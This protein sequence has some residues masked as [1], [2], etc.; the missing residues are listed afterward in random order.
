MEFDW[1]NFIFSFGYISLD[2][3]HAQVSSY[4]RKLN[5]EKIKWGEK[6]RKKDEKKEERADFPFSRRR[7]KICCPLRDFYLLIDIEEETLW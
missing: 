7:K 2:T 1:T 5:K 4:S 3:D 6:E